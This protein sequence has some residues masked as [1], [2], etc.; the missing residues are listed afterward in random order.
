MAQITISE[1]QDIRDPLLQAAA[2]RV[3]NAFVLAMQKGAAHTADPAR[4]PIESG[5]DSVEEIIAGLVLALPVGRQLVVKGRALAMIHISR[6]CSGAGEPLPDRV[7]TYGEL[8]QIDLAQPAPILDQVR[9]IWRQSAAVPVVIS[10]PQP[11]PKATASERPPNLTVPVLQLRIRGTKCLIETARAMAA[12][13]I[14]VSGF[15]VDTSGRAELI[16][17]VKLGDFSR[18]DNYA[19]YPALVVA[20][21]DVSAPPT[22][23]PPWPRTYFVTLLLTELRQ[24]EHRGFA[25]AAR[26][27][28]AAIQIHVSEALGAATQEPEGDRASFVSGL[29]DPICVA[30]AIGGVMSRV[31]AAFAALFDSKIFTSV[32][33]RIDVPALSA[34]QI[35]PN[36]SSQMSFDKAGFDGAYRIYYDWHLGEEQTAWSNWEQL[37]GELSSGPASVSWDKHRIDVF[38]RGGDGQMWQKIWQDAHSWGSWIP[39]GGELDSAPAAVSWGAGRLDCFCR[40]RDNHLRHKSWDGLSWSEWEDLGGEITSAPA[41]ATWGPNRLDVFAR[42]VGNQLLHRSYTTDAGW[43]AWADLGGQLLD[44]PAVVSPSPGSLHVYIHGVPSPTWILPA[45][46]TRDGISHLSGDGSRWGAW[47]YLGGSMASAPAACSSGPDRE[48]VFARGRDDQLYH[49]GY[50]SSTGWGEWESLGG[51]LSDAPAV[52]AN[53]GSSVIDCFIKGVDNHLWQRWVWGVPPG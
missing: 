11:P 19:Y 13:E 48:D 14:H 52:V 4:F 41:A 21:F 22:Y 25:E 46:M 37:D 3:S 45:G 53:W 24:G 49:K 17:D 34:M 28:L 33:L 15:T 47:E 32:T 12:D 9:R 20:E 8:A 50:N 39:L 51:Q 26:R 43:A 5:K 38:V 1:V 16:A 18:S 29:C 7:R 30:E 31:F 42:G 27:L 40:T 10:E 23:G 35:Q 6:V 2:D 44:A 36:F